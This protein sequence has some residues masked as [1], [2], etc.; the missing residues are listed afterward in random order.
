MHPSLRRLVA[1]T[2]IALVA[3]GA[4]ALATGRLAY[5]VTSGASMS[6]TYDAGDLVVVA[7]ARSYATG[8]VVAYPTDDLVVL[9]R[10]VGGDATGFHT[11]GDDN[12]SVDPGRPTADEVTGRAVLHVPKVGSLLTS[13][14]TRG[15]LAAAALSLLGAL[16]VNP[17]RKPP[18]APGTARPLGSTRTIWTGL[19]ALD[20]LLLTAMGLAFAF[21]PR[22]V[23]GPAALTQTGTLGYHA[24]VPPSDTYPTGHVATGDPVFLRLLDAVDVSFRYAT[25][26]SP[27]RVEGTARLD[28]ALSTPDGWQTTLPLAEPAPLVDGSIA[29]T[30]TLD[31]ADI[32]D[33][34]G[35][36]AAATGSG[37]G[38]VDVLVTAS[39]EASL[40]GGDPVAHRTELALQLSPLALTLTG[41]EPSSTPEGPAVAST[42]PFS[43]ARAIAAETGGVPGEVR[44]ALVAALLLSVAGTALLWPAS[45]RSGDSGDGDS[46]PSQAVDIQLPRTSAWVEL[47][48]RAE[49]EQLA[50]NLG[51]PI[52]EGPGGWQGVATPDT[53]YWSRARSPHPGV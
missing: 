9:H 38:R 47:A 11:K 10:I 18:P 31:L 3:L 1:V 6:P 14:L 40:D 39:G 28:A 16:I 53:W 44:M 21:A 26:A 43:A 29:L 19:V 33:L 2:L 15:L 8:D 4:A 32:G 49:L 45:P 46:R 24:D 7:P 36:V 27:E 37:S 35:R 20:L 30:A 22:S 17:R 48:D 51:R 42:V 25:D 41:V 23:T 50:R 12:Q 5:Y 52:V 13:P 34:A